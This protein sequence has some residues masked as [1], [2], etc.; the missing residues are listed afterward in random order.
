MRCGEKRNQ[1]HLNGYVSIFAFLLVRIITVYR[2]S[3]EFSLLKIAN[4]V[5]RTYLLLASWKFYPI[6]HIYFKILSQV[7][8]IN[9]GFCINEHFFIIAF[10]NSLSE[11]KRILTKLIYIFTAV[12]QPFHRKWHIWKCIWATYFICYFM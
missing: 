1:P 6:L 4:I 9:V 7:E 12:N 3:C 8:A 2:Y 11:N 10:Q 5:F